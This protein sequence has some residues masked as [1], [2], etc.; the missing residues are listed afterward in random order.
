MKKS[1]KLL[2]LSR[3][4]ISDLFSSIFLEND[5]FANREKKPFTSFK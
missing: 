3:G 5:A 1:R 4:E 2:S